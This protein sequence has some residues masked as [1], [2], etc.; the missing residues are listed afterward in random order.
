MFEV[1]VTGVPD[2]MMGEKV[3]AVI[4]PKPGQTINA[5]ELVAFAKTRLADFKVPQ[6]IVVRSEAL[7]R[8]PGGKVLKK[9]LRE[10]V[11][12]GKRVW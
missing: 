5:N 8:N 9:Q 3:G 12:W 7:P 10:K 6:Y 2:T 11:D 1:A 4:V